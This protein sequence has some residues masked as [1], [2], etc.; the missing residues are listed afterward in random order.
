MALIEIQDLSKIYGQGDATTV[1]LDS[2]TLS[3]K[4]GEFVAIMGPS[5]SGKSTLMNMIGLL[6]SPTHGSY[7]LDRQDMSNLRQR[8]RAKVRRE[9]IGFIFQT[10]NLL[11]RMNALDNVALPLMYQ[12]VA[13][14]ER[15][16]LAAKFLKKVDLED[17]Q[18]AMP[19]QLSGGQVQR[20]AVARALVNKPKLVLADEPTGNLDTV[21]SQ[22]IMKLLKDINK[23]GNTI[24]MV[25]HEP[26]LATYADRVIY[27]QDGR[28]VDTPPHLLP[29]KKKTKAAK[30]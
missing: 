22:R 14:A 20:V 24:L 27:F 18:L 1:A 30:S 21:A 15:H 7:H 25:T 13:R 4:K 10:F 11:P 26:E 2:V 5:G 29:P 16:K 23:G 12:R 28:I 3:I 6:D 9:Q 19:N 17:R 8:Q